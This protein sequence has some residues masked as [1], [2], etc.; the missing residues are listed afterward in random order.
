MWK[1]IFLG[2]SVIKGPSSSIDPKENL[3]PV[4]G[5]TSAAAD[6]WVSK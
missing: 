1:K 3:S 6:K 4:K 5:T 2:V